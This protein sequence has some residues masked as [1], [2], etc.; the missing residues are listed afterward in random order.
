MDVNNLFGSRNIRLQILD[1]LKF[2]PDSVLLRLE[3]KMKIGK[4]LNLKNPTTFNEKLQWLKLHDR[5]PIYTQMADKYGVREFVSQKIGYKYLVP[6]YGV[7]DSVDEVPFDELP[8]KFVMKCTHDSGSVVLCTDKNKFDYEDAKKKLNKRLTKN[9]FWWAREWPYRNIKP[10]VI[11][12]EYLK[13]WDNEYLP[14]YKVFCFDG[15]PKLIQQIQ[16]DK[17]EDE[18]VDYF[19]T[20]WQRQNIKQRFP[21]S[22]NPMPR[23]KQL[24]KMLDLARTISQ[25][26]PF[27][28]VDFYVVNEEIIFSECTFYTD[29]GY[30][31]FEPEEWDVTLGEWLK[32]D[33]NVTDD[34]VSMR[35]YKK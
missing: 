5:K 21:N 2:I 10:R 15:V 27:L 3:Y 6:I 25:G 31:I 4:K 7:W 12:E 26:V 20:E 8:D 34:P 28:R 33:E 24:T 35:G 1:M 18:T 32:I 19:D 17:Q 13:D 23:P 16:N 11:V 30:S 22:E 9:A 29:A 14:V